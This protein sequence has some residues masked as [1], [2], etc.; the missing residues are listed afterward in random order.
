LSKSNQICLNP[1]N[2][3]HQKNLLR[4]A[5][6]SPTPTALQLPIAIGDVDSGLHCLS[7]PE[8]SLLF[9]WESELRKVWFIVSD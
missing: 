1:I 2:F 5:A 9:Y 8:V 6:A 3:A 4:G 7:M